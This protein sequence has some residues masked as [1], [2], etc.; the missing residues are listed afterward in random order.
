MFFLSFS[1]QT[2]DFPYRE[3]I[4]DIKRTMKDLKAMLCRLEDRVVQL[5]G[6]G[7][8]REEEEQQQEEEEGAE[9]P[10]GED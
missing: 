7:D 4:A 3:E 9:S 1:Q 8:Q 5:E 6:K 10:S 2:G